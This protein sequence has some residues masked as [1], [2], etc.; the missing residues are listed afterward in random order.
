MRQ[1]PDFDIF[2][3]TPRQRDFCLAVF[4]INEGERI[5]SQIKKMRPLTEIVDL[6]IA[7]GGSTD[8]SLD[9]SILLENHVRTLLTKTG[10]GRLSA[11]M[12]MAFVYAL[13]QGYKGSSLLTATTRMTLPQSQPL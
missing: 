2:E 11:Q 3:L 7:D 4:V 8:G 9:Q 5:R 10:P 1:V 12:R 6:I 13:D